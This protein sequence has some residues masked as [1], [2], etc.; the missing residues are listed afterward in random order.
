[1]DRG[2]VVASHKV[3]DQEVAG[4]EVAGQEVAGQEVAGQ[5]VAGRISVKINQNNHKR[6][7]RRIHVKYFFK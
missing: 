7:D 2:L 3:A 5:E 6:L 1:M 4:Q